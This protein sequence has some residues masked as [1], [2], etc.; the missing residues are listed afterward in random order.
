MNF[1]DPSG[2]SLKSVWNSVKNTASKVVT[3]VKN[4]VSKVTTAV[5]NTATKVVNTVKNAVT[6][7]SNAAKSAY[8]QVKTAVSNVF[9]GGGN[10]TSS[11][12]S[13]TASSTGISHKPII[14]TDKSS[15][16]ATGSSAYTSSGMATSYYNSSRQTG[17]TPS[18][19]APRV[20]DVSGNDVYYC[21]SGQRKT[22]SYFV[23]QLLNSVTIH[24][25]KT[26]EGYKFDHSLEEFNV[27]EENS[28]LILWFKNILGF[29]RNGTLYETN[30]YAFALD[31]ISNP[32][33]NEDFNSNRRSEEYALQP[34]ML[35]GGYCTKELFNQE[36]LRGYIQLIDMMQDDVEVL[37]KTMEV[38]DPL[39]HKND[40]GYVI[41]VVARHN[42]EN[43]YNGNFH[44][45]RLNGNQE[46]ESKDGS[47]EAM[48][49]GNNEDSISEIAAQM[50]YPDFLG[51]YY[52]RDDQ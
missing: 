6:T 31:L 46:W 8:N 37:G 21:E 26:Y 14:S 7:V 15:T 41:A 44:L 50:G 45:F 22:S 23:Q 27:S 13:Y 20:E 38:Y 2:Q 52:I 16:G 4:T 36:N 11:G 49:V 35:S 1:I 18:P 28:K 12:V 17:K 42:D 40:E 3:S 47:T 43:G 10:T 39:I 5:K 9:N 51:L 33:T 34:G 24:A 19:Y 48:I 32:L 30:C 29:R 25:P